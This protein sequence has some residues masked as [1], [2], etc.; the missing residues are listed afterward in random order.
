MASTNVLVVA[1]GSVAL[2]L[3]LSALTA[4]G[5]STAVLAGYAAPTAGTGATGAAGADGTDGSN[6]K[7]GA[8]GADGTDGTTGLRG[9]GGAQGSPGAQGTTGAT[10]A[11]G[12][13]GPAG[14][15]GTPAAAALTTGPSTSSIVL[16]ADG[17][18]VVLASIPA[19]AGTYVY[20]LLGTF[21]VTGLH[22]I[23]QAYCYDRGHSLYV[24]ATPDEYVSTG[25]AV[26]A[27][28]APFEFVCRITTFG[29]FP[30]STDPVVVSWTDLTLLVAPLQ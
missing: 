9:V 6:G 29:S 15:A 11:S 7:P 23:D 5:V 16:P 12:S 25:I 14:P 17:S 18:E 26:T 20:S 21:S 27:A 4:W 24:P 28:P 3:G 1:A 2:C 30:A 8:T 19:P 22:P 10:G 13:P